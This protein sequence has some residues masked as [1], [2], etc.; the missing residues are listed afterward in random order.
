VIAI[1]ASIVLIFIVGCDAVE[2]RDAGP[3]TASAAATAGPRMVA[4]LGRLEPNDGIIRIAGP[5]RPT[6]VIAKLLVEEGDRVQAGQPIAVLDTVAE[7]EARVARTRAEL[8]NAE[9]ELRRID[10]LFRQGIAA[11]SMREDAQ[12]KVDVARAELQAAQ[13]AV[14]SD[15]VHAPIAG[16][17]IAIHARRGERVGP[18]GIAEIGDTARMYAVAE[19]YETDIGRVKAGQHATLKSPALERDLT[20]VVDRI[21]LK[22]SQ[23]DL[24]DADPAARTDARIVEVRIRLDDSERAAA[25]SNLQVEALIAAD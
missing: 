12:L 13:S 21:G 14:D 7:N 2:K 15:T 10:Q 25:L 22:V 11:V 17:V 5:S 19:V 8:V 24:L 4:A 9:G 20:G 18:A 1:L 16:Q 3:T 23:L 6:A